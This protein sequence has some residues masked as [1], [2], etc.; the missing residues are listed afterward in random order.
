[1]MSHDSF[2]KNTRAAAE[3]LL[4]KK[5]LFQEAAAQTFNN[6]PAPIPDNKRQICSIPQLEKQND[7]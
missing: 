6:S 1:M 7:L 4:N 5:C 3:A 2:Q